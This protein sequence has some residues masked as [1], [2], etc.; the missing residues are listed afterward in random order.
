MDMRT[1][2]R[3]FL[4]S[5]TIGMEA[6]QALI[7][8]NCPEDEWTNFNALIAKLHSM[9][10]DGDLEA[11]DRLFMLTGLTGEEIRKDAEMK[12]KDRESE[13]KIKMMN[14]K[15]PHDKDATSDDDNGII[16]YLPEH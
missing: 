7:L 8:S 10:M 4:G 12:R 13:A 14:A 2:V 6:E 11:M 16:V 15:I 9:S 3:N 5:S 1:L